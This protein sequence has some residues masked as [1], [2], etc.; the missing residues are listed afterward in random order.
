MSF[1]HVGSSP[2]ICMESILLILNWVSKQYL[3][4]FH[5]HNNAFH[6]SHLIQTT[7]ILD[8]KFVWLARNPSKGERWPC[9]RPYI[10]QADSCLCMRSTLTNTENKEI[11]TVPCFSFPMYI[12]FLLWF[13]ISGCTSSFHVFMLLGLFKSLSKYK[14]KIQTLSKITQLYK[15][16]FG[17]F[18]FLYPFSHKCSG[19]AKLISPGRCSTD[20]PDREEPHQNLKAS[21]LLLPPNAPC[22]Q[23]QTQPARVYNEQYDPPSL[24]RTRDNYVGINTRF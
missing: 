16:G 15:Q 14:Q 1:V 4:R 2:M 13:Q 11:Q 19:N 7:A 9:P 6:T 21:I 10:R 22:W 20:L 18:T 24:P 17:I 3:H 12:C 8:C 23:V 5:W